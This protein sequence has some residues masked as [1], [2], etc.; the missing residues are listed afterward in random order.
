MKL[1]LAEWLTWKHKKQKRLRVPI[2][3]IRSGMALTSQQ[4]LLVL[5]QRL[6]NALSVSFPLSNL[7]A[8]DS[9]QQPISVQTEASTINPLFKLTKSYPCP[10]Q[11]GYN[12]QTAPLSEIIIQYLFWAVCPVLERL[13]WWAGEAPFP[14]E[15]TQFRDSFDLCMPSIQQKNFAK[16][17][18]E[19][20]WLSAMS[21]RKVNIT[22]QVRIL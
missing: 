14:D 9:S 6:R 1:A 21:R 13:F 8:C 18:L 22:C 12:P 2:T 15:T 5:V 16:S 19:E 4:Q 20:S 10:W 3:S 11:H 7:L 17:N